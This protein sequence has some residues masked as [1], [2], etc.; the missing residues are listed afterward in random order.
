MGANQYRQAVDWQ[1]R[2]IDYYPECF[3]Y[4]PM[5]ELGIGERV[6]LNCDNAQATRGVSPEDGGFRFCS[7]CDTAAVESGYCS[8]CDRPRAYSISR[9]PRCRFH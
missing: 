2:P 7:L 4:I 6:C 1:G 9:I 3:A 8:E 5:E